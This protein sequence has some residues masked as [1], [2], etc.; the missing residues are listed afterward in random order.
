MKNLDPEVE[1]GNIEYKRFFKNVNKKKFYSFTAQMNW[2]LNEG[3]GG[4]I[5]LHC[6]LDLHFE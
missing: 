2:R 4:Q 6:H 3:N 5:D 1:S